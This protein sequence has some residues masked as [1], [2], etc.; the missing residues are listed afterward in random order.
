MRYNPHTYA[1]GTAWLGLSQLQ[2][3]T[4]RAKDAPCLTNAFLPGGR[5]A[6]RTSSEEPGVSQNPSFCDKT[7]KKEAKGGSGDRRAEGGREGRSR[8][9][10]VRYHSVRIPQSQTI[11][12]SAFRSIRSYVQHVP[13]PASLTSFLPYCTQAGREAMKEEASFIPFK[14][15]P[16][17]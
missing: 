17:L 14:A 16:P 7:R 12:S 15:G 5:S 11:P 6:R 13:S 8:L 2:T 3:Q 4:H 9:H 1:E 10:S